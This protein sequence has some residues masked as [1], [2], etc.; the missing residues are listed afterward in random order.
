[1]YRCSNCGAT[2]SYPLDVCPKCHVLL[3]GIKCEACQYIGTKAEFV[4]NAN[5]CPK[6]NVV[7]LRLGASTPARPAFTSA[8]KVLPF[9]TAVPH[10]IRPGDKLEADA[11]FCSNYSQRIGILLLFL[12]IIPGVLYIWLWMRSC[13]LLITGNEVIVT[14]WDRVMT[15]KTLSRVL[16]L[17]RPQEFSLSKPPKRWH[18]FG[19]KVSLP[20]EIATFL[21]RDVVY[22]SKG[23]KADE[24]FQIA[25]TPPTAVS[26]PA[27]GMP[28]PAGGA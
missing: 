9:A 2:M 21:G 27:P 24:A 13:A 28:L 3:S 7:A 4:G 25:Q 5:R 10:V 14:Q 16:R 22:V 23:L 12:G 19:N 18:P 17:E 20:A 6:C 1:V 15:S 8:P 11:I 26:T